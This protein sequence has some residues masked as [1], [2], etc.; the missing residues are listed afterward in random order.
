MNVEQSN[1]WQKVPCAICQ[2]EKHV[3]SISN[4][5]QFNIPVHVVMC[6]RCGLI[7]LNPRWTKQKYQFFYENKY[8]QYYRPSVKDDDQKIRRPTET[9]DRIVS[10]TG[11]SSFPSVL[12]IGSGPGW[13]LVAA[14]ERLGAEQLAAI[15][16]SPACI[17]ALRQQGVE[18]VASDIDEDWHLN[19]AQKYDLIIMRHA[20]EHFLDPLAVLKKIS[21]TL[22]PNGVVYIAVPDMMHPIRSLN[23][24]WYRAVHTYYFS[25]PTLSILCSQASLGFICGRQVKGELYGI[26]KPGEQQA[27]PVRAV[28]VISQRF[29]LFIHRIKDVILGIIP[30]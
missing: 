17:E 29:V 14:K 9:I 25:V 11:R 23:S 5:G 19:R 2:T 16:P 10:M 21:H 27:L 15:E 3:R 4:K 7:Y 18:H 12:D 1:E 8:D 20:L 24:F 26:A 6:G 13:T 28:H 30:R 22:K